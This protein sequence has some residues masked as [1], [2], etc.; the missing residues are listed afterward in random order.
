ME[1]TPDTPDDEREFLRQTAALLGVTL[2][3]VQIDQLLGFRRWLLDWNTRMNLTAITDPHAV[4]TRH[5][6]DSL[7]CLIACDQLSPDQPVRLLDVG[8]GAGFPGLALAIAR[9]KWQITL[10]EATGKKVR[11]QQTVIDDLNPRNVQTVQGR[12]E[13]L[14]HDPS[15]R[16]KF[17]VVTARALAALPIVLEWCQPFVAR[18]GMVLAQKKGDLIAEIAQGNRAARI[19]GGEHVERI[20]LPNSLTATVPDLADDRAIL[21][22][23]QRVLTPAIYPRSSAATAK[24]PLG[25]GPTP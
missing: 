15:W 18:G 14:A 16:G 8:S 21:R 25:S 3:D 10:L 9:P 22:V 4:L 13:D 5:I 23:R 24:K 6:L 11:F 12:A 17:N 19:L 2:I 7:T 20:A 1:T